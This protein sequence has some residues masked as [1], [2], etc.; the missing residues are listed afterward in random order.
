MDTSRHVGTQ[1]GYS[2][3]DVVKTPKLLELDQGEWEGKPRVEIYTP[4]V[5]AK[6]NSNNWNFTPPS[7]ESQRTVEERM[8]KWVNENLISRYLEEITTG[9]F[10]HGM[11]IKCLD[12]KSVV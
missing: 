4:K 3:D 7:G 8:L 1:L 5:L 9:I 6:I 11:A 2:L 12:R 10:T